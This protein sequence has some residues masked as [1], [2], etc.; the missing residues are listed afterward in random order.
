MEKGRFPYREIIFLIIFKLKI[1]SGEFLKFDM[2]YK[3]LAGRRR[4]L[5][6]SPHTAPALCDNDVL[7]V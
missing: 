2:K 4:G 1:G 7:P 3:A 6:L 5:C